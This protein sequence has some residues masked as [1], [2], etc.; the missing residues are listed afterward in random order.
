MATLNIILSTYNGEKYIEEQLD[1]IV[2]QTYQDYY[3]LIRDDG[4]DDNT[5]SVIEDWIRKN[6]QEQKFNIIEGNNIG[7]CK[8]FFR[9]LRQMP[10]AS[11]VA[12]C[13]QDDV[14]L[15]EKCEEAIRW[16]EKEDSSIPL[17]YH[18]GF[19]FGDSNLKN[20]KPYICPNFKY[21]FYNSITSNIFFGFAMTINNA[22]VQELLKANEDEIK[23]H[24]WFVAMIIVA[25]GK[26]QIGNK[27]HA[28]HRIHSSNSSPL[29]FLRKIPT[30]IKLLK[31]DSF[32]N[33]QAREFYRIYEN[34]LRQEEKVVIQ[35]FLGEKY[36]ITTSLK[37][38]FY[39][40]RWNSQIKIEII[41]RLLMLIGK[42]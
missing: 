12:F 27:P 2:R 13:D 14:W 33:K 38:C 3:V 23:Y 17:L 24:D 6:R 7:F 34:E 40:K 21:E 20:R 30:G 15:P 35:Y 32:Y 37:K 39:P 41:Q 42:I 28:I 8:S 4:S 10:K 18:S 19:E 16:L 31:G 26:Y 29:N 11:Y 1:S 36:S 22:L 25:F 9:L 5:V